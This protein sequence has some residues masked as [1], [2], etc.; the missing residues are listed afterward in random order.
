MLTVKKFMFFVPLF[1]VPRIYRTREKRKL[2][3]R[4]DL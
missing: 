1:E 2:L 3:T 4:L